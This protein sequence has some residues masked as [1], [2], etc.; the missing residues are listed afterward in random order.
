VLES[1][2]FAAQAFVVPDRAKDFGAKQAVSLRFEGAI[3]DSFRFFNLAKRP[4][5]DHVRRRQT[6]ANGIKIINSSLLL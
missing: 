2:V 5:T 1:F 6:D 4:R 3:V